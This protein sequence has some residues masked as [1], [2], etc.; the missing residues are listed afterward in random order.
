MN[1]WQNQYAFVHDAV[2]E[3]LICGDTRIPASELHQAVQ[4][5]KQKDEANEGK[6]GFEQQ[7]EVNNFFFPLGLPAL[8]WLMKA[9]T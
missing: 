6:T 7:F 9:C 1:L 3:A 5:L 4:R 2:L 8:W